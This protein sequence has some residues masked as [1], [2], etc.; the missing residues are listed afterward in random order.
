MTGTA[1]SPRAPSALCHCH[2]R[3]QGVARLVGIWGTGNPSVLIPPLVGKPLWK[4]VDARGR[5]TG[6]GLSGLEWHQSCVTYCLAGLVPLDLVQLVRTPV[7]TKREAV[8]QKARELTRHRAMCGAICARCLS[9]CQRA[10]RGWLYQH[11][12]L[13]FFLLPSLSE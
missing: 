1:P 5:S 13:G 6:L 12:G 9:W 3:M 2:T 8:P 7:N 11:L 10:A 4:A